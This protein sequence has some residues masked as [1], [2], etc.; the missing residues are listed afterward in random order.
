MLTREYFFPV[1]SILGMTR[2]ALNLMAK[3]SE[4]IALPR[5]EPNLTP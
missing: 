2:V 1:E 4:R 3:K 5:N